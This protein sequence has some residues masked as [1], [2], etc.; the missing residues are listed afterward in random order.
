MAGGEQNKNETSLED[1][2]FAAELFL[3]DPVIDSSQE[4]MLWNSDPVQHADQDHLMVDNAVFQEPV[5]PILDAIA[6]PNV[7]QIES[8]S[9]GSCQMN[10]S[11]NSELMQRGYEPLLVQEQPAQHAYQDPLMD[12]AVLQEPVNPILYAS[13]HPH[14][15][16]TESDPILTGSGS[17]FIN[18]PQNNTSWNSEL[19]QYD[20]ELPLAEQTEPIQVAAVNPPILDTG[21]LLKGSSSGKKRVSCGSVDE[22]KR[23]EK[24]NSQKR[25]S[26]ARLRAKNKAYLEDI[27]AK[28]LRM[29]EENT[30]LTKEKVSLKRASN[31]SS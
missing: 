30:N 20:S 19:V 15:F 18:S 9:V 22:E 3:G 6:S 2:L 31:T 12:H 24:R 13:A 7:T 16:V 5:D 11:C 1:L 25:E 4:N 23:R 8:F 27:E 21:C 10:P 14:S 26:A 28:V 29:Q 17:I